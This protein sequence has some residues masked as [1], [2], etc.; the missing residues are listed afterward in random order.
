MK[1]TLENPLY[2]FESINDE[3]RIK[4]I[5]DYNLHFS[6]YISYIIELPN[7]IF[8]EE[9]DEFGN[10]TKGVT[11]VERE[12]TSLLLRKLEVSK[13][14][15]KN[16]YIKNEPHQNRNYLNIQFNTIQ[17]IIF[18]NA[19]LINRYPCL[20][21]PLR[22]LVEF[23]NDILLYPD[24]EKFELNEDGIQFEPSSDQQGSFILKTDRE[25]IH[26]VLDYMKGENEKRETILSAEDFNQLME[27][28][29]Y[30]IEQEQ[31]PEITK[32]LKPKLPNELIRF[33]FAVLHRELY[34]TKRKRVYFYDFIKLVFENFKNTSL[35][36]IESQ[37][38]TKPRIYPHSFIPEIIKK[39]IE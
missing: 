19:D 4:K 16:S 17:N 39:H 31:I 2:F 29:T 21:L 23:I 5:L 11:T 1:S 26:E 38:G 34:T 10:V 22:G 3:V 18:K 35:K 13:E 24:M 20:L 28:T 12:L 25:I 6:N 8:Y 30:L 32:Q 9:R 15:M 33:T 27:Y 37:F 36:S 7:D 14:L